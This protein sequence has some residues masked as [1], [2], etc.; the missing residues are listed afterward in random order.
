MSVISKDN[1]NAYQLAPNGTKAFE[2]LGIDVAATWALRVGSRA[3]V[4]IGVNGD[5]K[6]VGR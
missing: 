4:W 6:Q 1:D 3:R 2:A 5:L